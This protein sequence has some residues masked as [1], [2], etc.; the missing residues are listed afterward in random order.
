MGREEVREALRALGMDEEGF[1]L[2]AY[3]G[4]HLRGPR[5]CELCPFYDELKEECK[6][7]P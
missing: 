1:F 2:L 6:L 7:R 5:K 4:R 3:L